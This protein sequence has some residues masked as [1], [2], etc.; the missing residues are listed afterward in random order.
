MPQPPLVIEQKFRILRGPGNVFPSPKSKFVGRKEAARAVSA[1]GDI[2]PDPTSGIDSRRGDKRTLDKIITDN[3]KPALK[4]ITRFL[5]HGDVRSMRTHYPNVGHVDLKKLRDMMKRQYSGLSKATRVTSADD[6]YQWPAKNRDS[7]RWG[8]IL[9]SRGKLARA[10]AL[11]DAD[12]RTLSTIIEERDGKTYRRIK[13][14]FAGN[15]ARAMK[16]HYPNVTQS[17]LNEVFG[18]HSTRPTVGG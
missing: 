14:W 17:E 13:Q 12:P 5:V 1:H 11:P 9:R 8:A 10:R 2:L 3:D 6:T 16:L 15:Q 4:R 7:D 18:K